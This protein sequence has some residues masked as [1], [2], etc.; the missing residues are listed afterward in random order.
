MISLFSIRRPFACNCLKLKSSYGVISFFKLECLSLYFYVF[1]FKTFAHFR[2]GVVCS[3]TPAF[4]I[5]PNLELCEAPS[6]NDRYPNVPWGPSSLCR[7]R[8]LGP[9]TLDESS[10]SHD[11]INKCQSSCSSKDSRS[12][13]FVSFTFW[14]SLRMF[15][16]LF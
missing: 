11:L 13:S 9:W 5:W 8:E 16:T 1:T 10:F 14:M 2:L 12:I 3:K 7:V 6:K 4:C 15:P